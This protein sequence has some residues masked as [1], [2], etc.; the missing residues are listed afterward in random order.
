MDEYKDY[1]YAAYPSKITKKNID[2]NN[3]ELSF[4]NLNFSFFVDWKKVP[5]G[6]LTKRL[7]LKR[8]LKCKPFRWYLENVYPE[9][10]WFREYKYIGQVSKRFQ[11]GTRLSSQLIELMF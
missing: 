5:A 4:L 2:E 10:M 11:F 9:N 7:N 3:T 6:D 8:Q 1:I